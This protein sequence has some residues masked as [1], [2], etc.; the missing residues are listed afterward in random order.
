M[1]ITACAR[2][3]GRIFQGG[4]VIQFVEILLTAP[5]FKNHAHLFATSIQH[6][7]YVLN[8][9]VLYSTSKTFLPAIIFFSIRHDNSLEYH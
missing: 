8:E 2:G 5:T 3:L 4:G 1:S 7:K 6:I 9:H